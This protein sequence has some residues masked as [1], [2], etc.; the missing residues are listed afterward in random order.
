MT[1]SDSDMT[2]SGSN[3][4]YSFQNEYAVLKILRQYRALIRSA[5][6]ALMDLEDYIPELIRTRP[7][8]DHVD[9][10]VPEKEFKE[11]Y[12]D[13][14]ESL[15]G[16]YDMLSLMIVAQK[17]VVYEDFVDDYRNSDNEV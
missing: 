2:S 1:S 11:L 9:Y 10:L 15:E 17:G 7:Q 5:Q 4:Q 16:I 12:T 14:Y 8:F 6:D 3:P 13:A